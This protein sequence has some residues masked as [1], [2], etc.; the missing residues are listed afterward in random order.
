MISKYSMTLMIA[1]SL[2]FASGCH[3]TEAS[4]D[5]SPTVA[6]VNGI[7]ISKDRVD[8]IIQQ[9]A[10][11]GHPDS[12][13][14]RKQIIDNLATQILASEVASKKGL[15]KTAEV[16]A[17]LDL[18]RRS[19]LANAFVED[20]LKTHKVSDETLKTEYDKLKVQMGGEE[21]KARHILVKTEA[22]AKSIIAQLKKNPAAFNAIAKAK[23]QDPGSKNNGG[24]LGWFDP[25][26]MVPE[27][28]AALAKLKKGELTQEPVKT[29]FGYHI[30]LMEDS[31]PKQ[32]PPLDE[33]KPM[34]TQQIQQ[35]DLRKDLEDM[36]AKAKIVI[37]DETPK[38][39][40][41][42]AATLAPAATPAAS[43]PAAS[44]A[45]SA[46]AASAAE[47]S[48]AASAASAAK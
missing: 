28:G 16:G 12:P 8:M 33:V 23:S 6:T 40:A 17:Q 9:R 27:F 31:R 24:D 4:K 1:S 43:A 3:S 5:K 30:I 15:E 19:I 21:Y 38:P 2:L 37:K 41:A 29:Q 34:L 48:A 20:Y 22:E 13:E 11:Q 25:H 45:A 35:Q 47:S 14:A 10:S 44:A 39:A 36:K 42:P 18:A 32:I 46:P 7:P 26:S